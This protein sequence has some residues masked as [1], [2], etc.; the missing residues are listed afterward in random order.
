MNPNS[1]LFWLLSILVHKAQ[2]LELDIKKEFQALTLGAI[3]FDQHYV[4]HNKI[5]DQTVAGQV[6]AQSFYFKKKK[7]SLISCF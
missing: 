7:L 2:Q 6:S 1:Q 3:V 5:G 4:V